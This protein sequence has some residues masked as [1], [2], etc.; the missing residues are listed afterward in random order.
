MHR[1]THIQHLLASWLKCSQTAD[2]RKGRV[3]E[4]RAEQKTFLRRD[5]RFTEQFYVYKLCSVL[6]TS[7]RKTH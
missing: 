5:K 2:G 4:E 1:H 3:E 7:Q 6:Q